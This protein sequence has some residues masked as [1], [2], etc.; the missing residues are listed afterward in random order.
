VPL[1]GDIPLLGYLF[2][3][4]TK[5]RRKTNLLILLTPY[6]I[7]DQLD[8]ASIKERKLREYREFAASFAYLND[9][10]YEA[11]I[12]Y[13]RKRGLLEEINRT[14]LSVEEDRALLEAAGQRRNVFEGAVEYG[15][16]NIDAPDDP[17]P[18]P[19]PT[20]PVDAQPPAGQPAPAQPQRPGARP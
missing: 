10:K 5:T 12:D 17:A 7:K 19:A 1:L 6:I 15:P 18:A 3:Y 14:I 4:S 2:K 11:K 8:L 9:K 13:R 20:N 16:S